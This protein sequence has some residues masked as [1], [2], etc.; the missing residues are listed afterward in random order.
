MSIT[1]I[2]QTERLQALFQPGGGDV[3]LIT[4]NGMGLRPDGK[5]FAAAS[6]AAKL[7][8]PAIGIMS[9]EPNWFPEPDM[10]ELLPQLE[11]YLGIR[12]KRLAYG[13]SMGGYG[14]L[15]Y[16]RAVEAT[17][18][19]SLSPQSSVDPEFVPW[20]RRYRKYIRDFHQGERLKP[21]DAGGFICVIAD[22]MH[23]D[24]RRHVDI[25]H[26]VCSFDTVNALG[27]GHAT[28]ELF[29]SSSIMRDLFSYVLDHDLRAIRTLV[30]ERKRVL[31]DY[32]VR[33]WLTRAR[34]LLAK[35]RYPQAVAAAE[36][37]MNFD[38]QSVRAL[39]VVAKSYLGM[40]RFD[41][42]E[43]AIGRAEAIDI[44][45]LWLRHEVQR[46]RRSVR[47]LA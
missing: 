10:A 38:P 37:V 21:G 20:E 29:L 17:A 47:E 14:A 18:V 19:L 2:G 33:L 9:T 39:V 13:F 6:V 16:S 34:A 35:E 23:E 36:R 7:G 46:L 12:S 41:R 22:L 30:R 27:V 11:P 5:T 45:E 24:D 31:T 28:F 15:K 44:S 8:M 25:I 3:L 26:Q 40:R 43:R 1:V 4:F 32:P 42:A